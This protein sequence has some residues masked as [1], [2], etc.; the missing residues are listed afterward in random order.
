MMGGV[1]FFRNQKGKVVMRLLK[2]SDIQQSI[3]ADVKRQ[4]SQEES[5]FKPHLI[6]RSFP[7]G[8]PLRDSQSIRLGKTGLL[9]TNI[10]Q[11]P[12]SSEHLSSSE[13]VLFLY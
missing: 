7:K 2:A 11:D 4:Q 13:D 12:L 9:V 8:Y 6:V 1:L 3:R 5:T 10:S